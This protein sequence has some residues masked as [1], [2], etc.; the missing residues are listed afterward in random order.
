MSNDNEILFDEQQGDGRA[1][2]QE[3]PEN[4]EISS[5]EEEEGIQTS[6]HSML[7]EDR[8]PPQEI[9]GYAKF[10]LRKI[11]DG[12]ARLQEVPG[13]EEIMSE[14]K[15]GDYSVSLQERTDN[16]KISSEKNKLDYSI[17]PLEMPDSEKF[18][19]CNNILTT[20][21]GHKKC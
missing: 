11:S 17:P 12:R 21:F 14:E 9:P 1:P 13:D 3:I 7:Q 16:E 2:P 10:R 19:P 6:P 15:E 20:K 5:N 8:I 18:N 4:D